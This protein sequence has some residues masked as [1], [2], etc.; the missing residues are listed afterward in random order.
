MKCDESIEDLSY[1][2]SSIDD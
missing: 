2:T 1:L